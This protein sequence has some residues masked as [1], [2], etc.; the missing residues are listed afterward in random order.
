MTAV[1]AE[2]TF[3]AEKGDDAKLAYLNSQSLIRWSVYR[4]VAFEER[5]RRLRAANRR[6][7]RRS[8]QGRF[9]N[10]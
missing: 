1:C 2:P 4:M 7:R 10:C 8:G 9:I 5:R 6:M 3:R